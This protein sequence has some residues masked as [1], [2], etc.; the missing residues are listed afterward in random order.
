MILRVIRRVRW[1]ILGREFQS[2]RAW[3]N[4]RGFHIVLIMG[5]YRK[6]TQVGI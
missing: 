3:L 6:Y 1:I 2:L 4:G 5:F